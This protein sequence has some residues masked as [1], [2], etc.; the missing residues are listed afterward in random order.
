MAL[1]LTKK[2]LSITIL[3]R[4]I[5]FLLQ[6]VKHMPSKEIPVSDAQ[7]GM[8]TTRDILDGEGRILINSGARL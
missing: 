7:A 8:I 6:G 2:E 4:I 1:F 3:L 5:T